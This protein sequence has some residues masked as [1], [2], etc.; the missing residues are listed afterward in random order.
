MTKTERIAQLF[1]ADEQAVS[2]S[3][4]EI[5]RRLDVSRSLVSKVRQQL[6]LKSPRRRARI[7]GE[8]R[9]MH[10]AAIGKRGPGVDLARVTKQ[11]GD[12]W[13]TYDE[14]P[15]AKPEVREAFARLWSLLTALG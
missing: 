15:D 3:N 13:V 10:V 11:V 14:Q 8:L 7:G 2:L 1:G 12:A 9:W 5:A 6:G 4:G